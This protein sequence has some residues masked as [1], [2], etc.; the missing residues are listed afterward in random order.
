MASLDPNTWS[1][2]FRDD[3]D[4]H[5]TGN[6]DGNAPDDPNMDEPEV[7]LVYIREQTDNP[8]EAPWYIY[9]A[10]TD[11][12]L[13]NC[14]TRI[15]AV[16]YCSDQGWD[17]RDGPVASEAEEPFDYCATF[18]HEWAL[19]PHHRGVQRCTICKLEVRG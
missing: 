8:S 3:L 17:V 18:G 2:S 15:G 12:Y 9:N 13:F 10:E 14:W 11:D 4:R 19:D 1:Q 6:W 16:D 7:T 5:I